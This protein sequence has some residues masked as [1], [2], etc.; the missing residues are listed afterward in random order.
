MKKNSPRTLM[1]KLRFPE[2]RDEKGWEET[3]LGLEATFQKGRGVSKGEVDLIAAGLS[4][5]A[6]EVAAIQ[7]DTD[8]IIVKDGRMVRIPAAEL[9]EQAQLKPA[10]TS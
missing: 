1:P 10:P 4:P 6:P 7:T 9:R 2:F 3:T 8:L 5:F